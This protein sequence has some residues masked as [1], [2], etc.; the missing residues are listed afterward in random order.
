MKSEK[1]LER[2]IEVSDH[3]DS[4]AVALALAHVDAWS[5]HDWNKA[6]E[7]LAPDV[8][9][10][11]TS[12]QPLMNPTDVTGI[13]DYMDGLI[14]FAQTVELGSA[15]VIASIGDERN[16]LMLLTVKAALGPDAAK[17]T[18]PSARLTL[19]DENRKIKKQQVIFFALSD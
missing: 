11:A 10:T 14:K 18:L 2:D 9:V 16:S 6:R 5:N 7:M 1:A 13:D 15:H 12:T 8:H 19:F 17:V 4:P 3:Q